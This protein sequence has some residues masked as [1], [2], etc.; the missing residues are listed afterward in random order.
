MGSQSP[1]RL[2]DWTELNGTK[3][4]NCKPSF[5]LIPKGTQSF[6]LDIIHCE[7][8]I[9]R[10]LNF[11][12]CSLALNGLL[13]IG[14]QEKNN[15]KLQHS[16]PQ[17]IFI[18]S[19]YVFWVCHHF[20]CL[21]AKSCMILLWLHGLSRSRL[22]YPWFSPGKKIEMGFHFLIQGIFLIQRSNSG[23]LHYRQI[24]HHWATREAHLRLGLVQHD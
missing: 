24:L 3:I 16:Q 19:Y 22:L 20:C 12:T 14:D 23:L 21:V 4:L 1:T 2:S 7:R 6:T 9:Y 11:I 15:K 17:Q 5:Q 8:K 18:F 10:L 13:I